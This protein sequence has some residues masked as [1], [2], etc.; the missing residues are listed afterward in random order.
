MLTQRRYS[1]RFPDDTGRVAVAIVLA[2]LVLAVEV[3][4]GRPHMG[5]RG[6]TDG[7]VVVR[8]W[9]TTGKV[10]QDRKGDTMIDLLRM[11]FKGLTA[12]LMVIGGFYGIA[13]MATYTPYVG[14]ILI[15]MA[16]ILLSLMVGWV[17]EKG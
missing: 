1:G 7:L 5:T 12:L 3:P 16:V 17:I 13:L 8:G 9:T 2:S 11:F 14:Y 6:H 15:G 10:E 4:L